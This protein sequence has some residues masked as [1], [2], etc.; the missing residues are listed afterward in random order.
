MSKRDSMRFFVDETS[1]IAAGPV[2][3]DD[4]NATVERFVELIHHCRKHDGAIYAWS[5][6]MQTEV[7]PGLPLYDVL[8]STTTSI[9]LDRDTRA[10]L[11]ES[12]NRCVLWDEDD[13]IVKKP[14][15]HVIIDGIATTAHT[16]A[17]VYSLV[18]NA[19]GAA[20]VCIDLHPDRSGTLVISDGNHDE[21]VHFVH[22]PKA[23]PAFYRSLFE[24]ENMEPGVYIENAKLA[25]PNLLLH[26]NLAAQFAHFQSQYQ[27]V[28][29][30][31]TKH[32][33]VLNDYFQDAYRLSNGVARDVQ[34]LLGPHGVN[35][36]PESPNTRRDKKAMRE[37]EITV[38]GTVVKCE[39]HT[40][41]RKEIDR[42]YFH[43]GLKDI[44]AGRVII[45]IFRSHLK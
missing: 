15:S 25:F 1:F 43:P 32:L 13:H 5:E 4:L 35:L 29:P 9:E 6:L 14:N 41:I 22:D 19:H 39:W 12:L 18:S 8:Y 44:A 10:S 17:F 36:S 26:D 24:L 23:L 28:R 33:T 21:H 27:S 20:C 34:A 37:R 16:I 2:D 38:D 11:R 42:I 40:K 31:V 7:I 30:E 3:S 45:G